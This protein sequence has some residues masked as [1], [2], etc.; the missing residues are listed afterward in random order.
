MLEKTQKCLKSVR[1]C[2]R[3]SQ[4]TM[5]FTQSFVQSQ[6]NKKSS[7]METTKSFLYRRTLKQMEQKRFSGNVVYL[8]LRLS[9]VL[10]KVSKKQCRTLQPNKNA[11]ISKIRKRR[12]Q[13]PKSGEKMPEKISHYSHFFA[14]TG[15]TVQDFWSEFEI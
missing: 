8:F 13:L 6:T 9:I 4:T 1:K 15:N 11:L 7:H 12:L 5:P 3:K 14:L 2:H 10:H